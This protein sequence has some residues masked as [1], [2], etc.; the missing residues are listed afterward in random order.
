MGVDG[1]WEATGRVNGVSINGGPDRAKT[2]TRW[3][4][5]GYEW[6]SQCSSDDDVGSTQEV[7]VQP[8]IFTTRKFGGSAGGVHCHWVKQALTAL[9]W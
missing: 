3:R 6:Q 7:S 1:I 9:T 5:L 4:D 8:N 2:R